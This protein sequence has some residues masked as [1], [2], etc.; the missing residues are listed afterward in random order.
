MRRLLSLVEN[1]FLR[2]LEISPLPFQGGLRTLYV[3]FFQFPLFGLSWA[4]NVLTWRQKSAGGERYLCYQFKGEGIG[5][6]FCRFVTG[7]YLAKKF[8]LIMIYTPF[9]ASFHATQCDWDLLL[10]FDAG[11]VQRHFDA[12]RLGHETVI[13]AEINTQKA[14]APQMFFLSWLFRRNWGGRE[15]RYILSPYSFTPPEVEDPAFCDELFQSLKEKYWE[16]RKSVPVKDC[17]ADSTSDDSIRVSVIVRRGEIA[18]A[19]N[20]TSVRSRRMGSSRWVDIPWYLDMISLVRKSCCPH[21]LDIHVFSD[22]DDESEFEDLKKWQKLKIHLRDDDPEQPFTAFHSMVTADITICG[23][24]GMCYAGGVLSEGL[25]IVPPNPREAIYF[26]TL[27][28]GW[29]HSNYEKEVPA[30]V[31]AL[32]RKITQV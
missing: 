26:P 16:R 19:K 5:G 2:L 28:E 27:S 3:F 25:K 17:F 30:Q 18:K 15:T 20:S 12:E 24:T 31:Q 10:G 23:L 4:Q 9:E 14:S 13:M 22:A 8:D 6:Q 11:E 21:E 29:I 32:I 1:F 7:K